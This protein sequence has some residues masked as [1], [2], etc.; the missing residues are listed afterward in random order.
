MFAFL[1]Y[2]GRRNGATVFVA[3]LELWY[4]VQ[5][6][7]FSGNFRLQALGVVLLAYWI[8][9]ALF[10]TRERVEEPAGWR[11]QQAALP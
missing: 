5:V 6:H 10:M 9:G 11:S 1:S 3:G 8:L 2:P 7:C 4:C